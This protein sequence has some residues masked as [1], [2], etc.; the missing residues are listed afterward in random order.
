MSKRISLVDRILRA[1]QDE[2]KKIS[3]YNTNALLQRLLQL[4]TAGHEIEARLLTVR[5]A[6]AI[7]RHELK[8]TEG[9][10][11]A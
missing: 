9:A 11:D 5:K 7:S 6:L 1:A 10:K 8:A 2:E 3:P 4:D